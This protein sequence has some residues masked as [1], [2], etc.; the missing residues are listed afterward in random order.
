MDAL[1]IDPI[2]YA[3]LHRWDKLAL[4]YYLIL[5]SY[6]ERKAMDKIKADA[7]SDRKFKTNLPRQRK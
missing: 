3:N 2:T 6:N 1:R 7:E 5:K 4:Q